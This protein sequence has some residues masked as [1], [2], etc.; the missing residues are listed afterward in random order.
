VAHQSAC[1]GEGWVATAN[2]KYSGQRAKVRGGPG[3]ERA[4][5]VGWGAGHA[6]LVRACR[7]T[8]L[9]PRPSKGSNPQA[10]AR[11]HTHARVAHTGKKVW[12]APEKKRSRHASDAHWGQ[13]SVGGWAGQAG[14][15]RQG[16]SGRAGQAGSAAG[17]H[18]GSRPSLATAPGLTGRAPQTESALVGTPPGGSDAAG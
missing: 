17:S 16:G 2:R 7:H 15:V 11:T 18:A 8:S 14:R 5:R 9:H 4:T 10:L 6:A 12:A 13:V 3:E 1:L